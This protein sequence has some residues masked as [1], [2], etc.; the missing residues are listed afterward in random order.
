MASPP[1]AFRKGWISIARLPVGA[2]HDPGALSPKGVV[3]VESADVSDPALRAAV[4]ELEFDRR[5]P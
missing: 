4:A 1:T 2:T 3:R 5:R